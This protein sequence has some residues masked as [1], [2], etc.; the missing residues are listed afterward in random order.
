MLDFTDP[1]PR[2]AD[3][4]R[5]CAERGSARGNDLSFANMY[6]LRKK[7]GISICFLNGFLFRHYLGNKRLSGYG[8]PIG[9]GDLSAALRLI[10]CDARERNRSFSFCFLTND[11]CRDLEYQYPNQFEFQNDR[12]DSDYLFSCHNMI[13]LTGRQL[14]R[15][16]N[17]IA[18]FEKKHSN[19]RFVPISKENT[20]DAFFVEQCWFDEHNGS[21][22]PDL[23][24]EYGSIRESLDL[25]RELKLFGGI[26][27]V[28][29]MPW[30]MSIASLITNETADI[31]YE[32]SRSED[33]NA[34]SVLNR[35]TAKLF[36][37][38]RYLNF[39]ED[40]NIPELRKAKLAYFPELLLEKSNACAKVLE[41]NK[42]Q[43]KAV[44]SR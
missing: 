37:G 2:N 19:W 5:E 23:V 24:L 30:A 10:E 21:S 3:S 6:L 31:H 14:H 22:N 40:L 39:E 35:E 27:Y 38:C 41:P 28:N 13:H 32:K 16:R 12:G 11:Q 44:A 7:Y 4:V 18:Q 9:Q 34:Y 17:L 1:N 15:K 42:R 33:R 43:R 20:E 26:I 29:D 36:N 25:F 8:F